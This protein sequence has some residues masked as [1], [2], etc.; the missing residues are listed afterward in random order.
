MYVRGMLLGSFQN[1][2]H[3]VWTELITGKRIMWG[4][5]NDAPF[6]WMNFNELGAYWLLE[7]L[8]CLW[9]TRSWEMTLSC[10]S[11]NVLYPFSRNLNCPLPKTYLLG[12]FFKFA[13]CVTNAYR[14]CCMRLQSVGV[15]LYEAFS[16]A[17]LEL[18]MAWLCFCNVIETHGTLGILIDLVS[19]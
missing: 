17:L 19:C 18:L 13:G 10:H 12:F 3:R 9:V 1:L 15:R 2:C 8:V 7:R 14:C 5:E 16:K 6:I 4:T 11:K